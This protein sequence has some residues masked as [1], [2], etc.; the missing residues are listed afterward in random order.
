MVNSAKKTIKELSY[1]F[2]HRI[3]K[4]VKILQEEKREFILSRQF[5]KSGT[6]IGALVREAQYAES[7]ADFIQ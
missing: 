5:M 7:S 4:L 1:K 3:I 2:A 6:A